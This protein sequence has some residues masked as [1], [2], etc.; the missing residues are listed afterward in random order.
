MKIILESFSFNS[1][2]KSWNLNKSMLEELIYNWILSESSNSVIKLAVDNDFTSASELEDNTNKIM[3]DIRNHI[4][5]ELSSYFKA[6]PYEDPR[7]FETVLSD[8]SVYI[9]MINRLKTAFDKY[10][11]QQQELWDNKLESWD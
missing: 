3:N 5:P 9:H 6:N 2:L 4:I 11:L 10:T 8:N 1:F 7:M